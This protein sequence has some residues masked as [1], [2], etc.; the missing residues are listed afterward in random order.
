MDDKTRKKVKFFDRVIVSTNSKKILNFS[1]ENGVN[2]S[3][4]RP[5]KISKDKTPME[6]VV[7]DV[8]KVFKK[9][10]YSP[11]AFA[12]LQ[13]TSPFRKLSTINKACKVFLDKNMIL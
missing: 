6:E 2:T 5:E 7:K 11:Y 1:R 4:I 13:P 12:I 8:L 9:R 3:Y 10:D